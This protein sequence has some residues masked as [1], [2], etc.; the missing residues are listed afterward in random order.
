MTLPNKPRQ[1]SRDQ[2]YEELRYENSN[3]DAESSR[4]KKKQR[5]NIQLERLQMLEIECEEFVARLL[6]KFEHSAGTGTTETGDSKEST[7]IDAV[8]PSEPMQ[9]EENEY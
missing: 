5:Q 8:D 6:T 3:D 2:M 1:R 9:Q 4:L 7:E